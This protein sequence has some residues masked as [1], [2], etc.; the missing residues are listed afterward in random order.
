M[1]LFSTASSCPVTLLF[2]LQTSLS[3]TAAIKTLTGTSTDADA[4]AQIT[5][6]PFDDSPDGDIWDVQDMEDEKSYIQIY[7]DDGGYSATRQPF[8]S[9]QFDESAVATVVVHRQVLGSEIDR[10][11]RSSLRDVWLYFSDLAFLMIGDQL[12]EQANVE[13]LFIQDISMPSGP[14]LLSPEHEE[15]QNQRV[16]VVFQVTLGRG[17]SE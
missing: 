4:L 13:G 7:L 6:G 14:G 12:A 16:Q 8:Q 15:G 1:A 5:V 17:G 2:K 10:T 9:G 3:K 11:S